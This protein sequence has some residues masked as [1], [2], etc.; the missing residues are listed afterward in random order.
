MFKLLINYV[1]SRF[2]SILYGFTINHNASLLP[3]G[4]FAFGR[5]EMMPAEPEQD[6][7]CEGKSDAADR[8]VPA[9]RPV[10]I[11][12]QSGVQSRKAVDFLREQ[13]FDQVVSLAG[14]IASVT[15]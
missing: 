4:V 3:L 10:V 5:A 13:G 6:N 2:S 8:L 14:G 1:I 12:C 9:N 7:T 15:T 11:H